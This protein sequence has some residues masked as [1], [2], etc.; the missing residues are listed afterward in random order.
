MTTTGTAASTAAR[1]EVA[2]LRGGGDRAELAQSLEEL[3]TA[4]TEEG[5]LGTSAAA[6]EEAAG[7]WK[8]AGEPARE[9]FC[10]LLAATMQRLRG[11]LG[12][13]RH[14]LERAAAS[15]LPD[16][17]RRAFDVERAEQSLALGAHEEAYE[18]FGSVLAVLDSG[19]DAPVRARI[20]QR[21]AAAA[22]A[23]ERWREAASDLMDAE[24][25]FAAHGEP[26]E[27]EAAALGAA[28]AVARVDPA[29]A[30]EVWSAATTPA[31]RD[32]TAAAARGITGG[33][34]ALLAGDAEL[35][36]RRFDAARQGALDATDPIAYLA[37]VGE[38]VAAA[39]SLGDDAGAYARLATAWVTLG[40]L[41]GGEGGRRLVRPLLEGLRDR[42]GATRFAAARKA[43]ESRTEP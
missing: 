25:L 34:I 5:D 26:G 6:L 19:Q 33:R 40:D 8:G 42:L 9:G 4:A 14:N 2:R 3:A 35:A 20:L 11:D 23:G 10:L 13:A 22:T 32:G 18:A 28:L 17:V 37:A 7:I 39:E 31:P 21:R 29:T 43:Y 1:A 36:L 30:E 27:A 16:A 12:A 24:E 41:L 15:D 38:A